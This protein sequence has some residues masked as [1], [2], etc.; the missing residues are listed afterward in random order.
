MPVDP[1][2][3]KEGELRYL[4]YGYVVRLKEL[5]KLWSW[6]LGCTLLFGRKEVG[7]R[8][9]LHRIRCTLPF[10]SSIKIYFKIPNLF[11]NRHSESK[12]WLSLLVTRKTISL[13][14]PIS[15]HLNFIYLFIKVV[16][17]TFWSPTGSKEWTFF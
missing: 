9:A 14:F 2:G 4:W 15:Y 10:G 7:T 17:S 5:G 1:N 6:E 8:S 3:L 16:S 12:H 13:L 11:F